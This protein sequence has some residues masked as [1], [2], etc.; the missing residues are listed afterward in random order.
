MPTNVTYTRGLSLLTVAYLVVGAFVAAVHHYL[1]HVD[2]IKP[3][4]S[5]V[6]AILLWPLVLF[7][8]NM[9]L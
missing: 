1:Q 3:I 8:V 9:H 4:I 5:G 2:A 7:G 6:L